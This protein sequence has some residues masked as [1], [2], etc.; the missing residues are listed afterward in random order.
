V[1]I[2]KYTPIPFG[3]NKDTPLAKIK[4]VG[5]DKSWAFLPQIKARTAGVGV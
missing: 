3:I 4:E 5:Y 2:S 1:C